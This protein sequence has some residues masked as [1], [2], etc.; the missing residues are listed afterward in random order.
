MV[1][2][3]QYNN[4]K[5][6]DYT[7]PMLPPGNTPQTAYGGAAP[8]AGDGLAAGHH[9][10][11]LD[12]LTLAALGHGPLGFAGPQHHALSA[13]SGH[14]PPMAGFHGNGAAAG[15]RHHAA[16]PLA[17]ASAAALVAS[18]QA[19]LGFGTVLLVSNIAEQVSETFIA[20]SANANCEI[21]RFADRQPGLAVH[22]VR[23]V[24]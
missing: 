18:Q 15:H 16:N 19:L 17:A 6:R 3:L 5:S 7:N 20:V 10:L 22:V 1:A 23:R 8:G 13:Q 14:A 24:R 4:D 2:L 9:H 11:G 12:P 21:T